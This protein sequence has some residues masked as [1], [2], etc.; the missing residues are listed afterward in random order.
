MPSVREQGPGVPNWAL[1]SGYGLSLAAFLAC[2]RERLVEK[3]KALDIAQRNYEVCLEPLK[4]EEEAIEERGE[5]EDARSRLSPSKRGRLDSADDS[6]ACRI[7]KLARDSLQTSSS[8]GPPGQSETCRGRDHRDGA[9]YL[10]QCLKDQ[11]LGQRRR[12]KPRAGAEDVPATPRYAGV[13]R[14]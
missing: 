14:R 10:K 12:R 3:A 1:L 2:A 7:L 6:W 8:P 9:K 5:N 13:G 11:P 4:A